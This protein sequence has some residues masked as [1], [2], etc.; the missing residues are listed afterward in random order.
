[1]R[2]KICPDVMIEICKTTWTWPFI[3][4]ATTEWIWFIQR[5]FC[6][7]FGVTYFWCKWFYRL[8]SWFNIFIPKLFLGSGDIIREAA[9]QP[10]TIYRNLS[11]CIT[12]YI[13]VTGTL[14]KSVD[15]AAFLILDKFYLFSYIPIWF[16][17]KYHLLFVGVDSW[18]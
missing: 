17:T 8:N 4:N 18:H 5:Q 11:T 13:W 6:A 3:I 2:I 1:M 14:G 12:Y 9:S 15:C 7:L 10:Y 16:L